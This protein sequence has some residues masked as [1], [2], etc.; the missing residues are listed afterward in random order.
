MP[1]SSLGSAVEGKG[2]GV[3][4]FDT[5]FGVTLESA[6]ELRGAAAYL[7]GSP[8][9]VPDPEKGWDYQA[10]FSGFL[11]KASRTAKTFCDSA[12]DQ[13]KLHY[14]GTNGAGI[15]VVDLS[16]VNALFSAFESFSGALAGTLTGAV[17]RDALHANLLNGT[18]SLYYEGGRYPADA[19]ADLY[20]VS[21]QGGGAGLQNA[22]GAA[23]SSWSK[24]FGE[25]RPLLGVFVNSLTSGGIFAP[26]HISGYR[27]GQGTIQFV[28]DSGAYA[29]SGSP[30]GTSLLDKLFYYSY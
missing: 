7:A 25:S 1:L 17:A 23:V 11:S 22:L 2:L 18:V 9:T 29:P 16:Q 30:A 26:N 12:V 4:G 20:S 27:K 13:F 19:Y 28:I 14:G 6:Y 3:I 5:G 24:D 15:S 8:G 21:L 10:L